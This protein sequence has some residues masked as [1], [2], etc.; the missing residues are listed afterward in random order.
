MRLTGS[1][2]RRHEPGLRTGD[3][4]ATAVEKEERGRDGRWER[5]CVCGMQGSVRTVCVPVYAFERKCIKSE[6]TLSV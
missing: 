4:G 6:C 3:R 5:V 1:D 2:V